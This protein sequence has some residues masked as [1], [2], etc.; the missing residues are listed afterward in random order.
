VPP[1]R[2]D[3]RSDTPVTLGLDI[4]VETILDAASQALAS[5]LST[6]VDSGM[7]PS[8]EALPPLTGESARTAKYDGGGQRGHRSGQLASSWRVR[9]VKRGKHKGTVV[10]DVPRS[11][12]HRLLAVLGKRAAAL[13]VPSAALLERVNKMLG[14]AVTKAI[15]TSATHSNGPTLTRSASTRIL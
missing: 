9:R 12:Q 3:P 13:S 2:I 6:T 15:E 7:A 8:G 5:V 10:V 14:D 1:V 11:M 4:N